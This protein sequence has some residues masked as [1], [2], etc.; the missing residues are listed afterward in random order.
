MKR[1][2][3]VTSK[4]INITCD[5][6]G[7]EAAPPRVCDECRRDLCDS[8]AVTGVDDIFDNNYYGNLSMCKSCYAILETFREA[9]QETHDLHNLR[10]E[11]LRKEFDLSCMAKLRA[12]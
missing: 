1:E 9:V 5:V 4:K 7:N 11:Q 6:C 12:D 10:I 3:A 8:C 2:I